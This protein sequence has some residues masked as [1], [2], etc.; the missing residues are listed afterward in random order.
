MSGPA[1]SVEPRVIVVPRALE[2]FFYERLTASLAGRDDVRIMVDRRTGER[3][4]RRWA[5]GPGPLADRRHG[6]RRDARVVW[7]LPDMPFVA[8]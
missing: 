6:D 3:R 1:Q 8:T 2:D 5:S 4:R 7:S